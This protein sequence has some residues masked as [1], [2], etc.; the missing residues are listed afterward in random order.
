MTPICTDLEGNHYDQ[1]DL[2]T[3][4]EITYCRR[5]GCEQHSNN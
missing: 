4:R 5:C 1:H 2:T 3:F